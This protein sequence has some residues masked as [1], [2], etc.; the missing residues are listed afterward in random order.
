MILDPIS[1][2]PKTIMRSGIIGPFVS[3]GRGCDVASAKVA[4]STLLDGVKLGEGTIVEDSLIGSGVTV[5]RDSQLEGCIVADDVT[6]E[7]GSKLIDTQV[8]A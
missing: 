7:K 1:V 4:N 5:S 2:G 8:E 3:L 6:V